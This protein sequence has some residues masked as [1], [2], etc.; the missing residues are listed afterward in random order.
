MAKKANAAF[1]S[2]LFYFTNDHVLIIKVFRCEILIS[3][4]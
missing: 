3:I 1:G 2:T 4:I